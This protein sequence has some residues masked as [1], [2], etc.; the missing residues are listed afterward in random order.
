MSFSLINRLHCRSCPTA[1]ARVRRTGAALPAAA[2]KAKTRSTKSVGVE[3]PEA[4]QPAARRGL[5]A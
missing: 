1:D 3:E 5:L 2:T 4:P